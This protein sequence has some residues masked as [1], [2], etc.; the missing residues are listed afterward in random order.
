MT[1]CNLDFIFE[2]CR[3]RLKLRRTNFSD[4][5]EEA[6]TLLAT[7]KLR[8]LRLKG[9]S[10]SIIARM[11]QLDFQLYWKS[12]LAASDNLRTINLFWKTHRTSEGSEQDVPGRH[13][14]TSSF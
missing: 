13:R 8:R 14:N 2:F 3:L 7:F 11:Q 4:K 5:G 9:S 12:R 1:R 10:V 6:S